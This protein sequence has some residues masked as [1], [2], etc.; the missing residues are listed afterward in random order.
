MSESPIQLAAAEDQYGYGDVMMRR[1]RTYDRLL[2]T[3]RGGGATLV[4][5][6]DAGSERLKIFREAEDLFLLE[7]VVGTAI[8]GASGSDIFDRQIFPEAIVERRDEIVL[9]RGREPVARVIKLHDRWALDTE[10]F[11]DENG[12]LVQFS[13]PYT[14]LVAAI[15]GTARAERPSEPEPE[16]KPKPKRGRGAR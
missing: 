11:D 10:R 13:D 5:A 1:A 2:D 12:Q 14:A 3:I 6:H 4:H 16:A 8:A 7:E 9:F 15:E